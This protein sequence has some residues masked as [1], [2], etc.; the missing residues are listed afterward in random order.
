MNVHCQFSFPRV[1]GVSQVRKV[2]AL[3]AAA[4]QPVHTQHDMSSSR[5]HKLQWSSCVVSTTCSPHTP[6]QVLMNKCVT[7]QRHNGTST[8]TASCLTANMLS[9]LR[10]VKNPARHQQ[11][12][13]ILGLPVGVQRW[14]PDSVHCSIPPSDL[15][16]MSVHLSCQ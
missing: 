6:I 13:R 3:L 4:D 7:M 1:T 11:C 10:P 14:A 16:G 5:L 2:S 8:N 9:F 15:K 12:R